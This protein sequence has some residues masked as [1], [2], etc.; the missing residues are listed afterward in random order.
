M[1]HYRMGAA[2]HSPTEHPGRTP[3]VDISDNR[4]AVAHPRV[5]EEDKDRVD[6]PLIE[7][8]RHRDRRLLN[9]RRR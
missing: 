9:E 8:E 7:E 2:G 3:T 1:G 4:E 6:G 5:P